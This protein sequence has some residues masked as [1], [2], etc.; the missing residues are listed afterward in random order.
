MHACT[1]KQQLQQNLYTAVVN[2][3]IRPT[4]KVQV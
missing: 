2:N 4:L 3:I 1:K